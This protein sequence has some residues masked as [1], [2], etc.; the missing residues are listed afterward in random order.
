MKIL[1]PIKRVTDP[2]N[3]NKAKVSAD[4]K[5]INTDGMEYKINPYDEYALEAALRLNEN[6]QSN[7]KL[8]E[9][10]IV[11]VGPAESTQTLRQAL[12]MGADRAVLVKANDTDLDSFSVAQ[13][14]AKIVE[15]E[16][17]DLVLM[18]KLAVDSDANVCG[19]MLAELL[20][21]PMATQA[22]DL[23]SL[24]GGKSFIVGR[25]VDMGEM[26]IKIQ[27][28]AVITS[29]DRILAPQAVRN[30]VTPADHAYPEAEGGRYA[31]LKGIM[32][33][34][35]KPIDE[36]ELSSLGITP[37]LKIKHISF[38]LPAAR[39]GQTTFVENASDLVNKL[40]SESKVI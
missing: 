7:E 22:Q 28:P 27:T 8:G 26:R 17:P 30:G 35:K 21:W 33:A 1:V 40:R 3:A 2:D 39:S 29:A 6:A 11:S 13:I 23:E 37:S 25:E 36:L 12:A 14:L 24:D 18:G 4:G 5:S 38:S 10:I 9:T 32:A 20:G 31:S 15:K 16:Q 34:K 19:Q